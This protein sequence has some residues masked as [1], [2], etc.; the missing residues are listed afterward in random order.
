MLARHIPGDELGV[1][2]IAEGIHKL[3]NLIGGAVLATAL[4]PALNNTHV[5]TIDPIA[6]LMHAACKYCCCKKVEAHGLCPANASP[7][8]L[9]AWLK[10]SCSPFPINGDA[11]AC[12]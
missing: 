9:L 1:G 2:S 6:R 11:N 12:L 3:E 5:I 8:G 7:I 4:P 10:A